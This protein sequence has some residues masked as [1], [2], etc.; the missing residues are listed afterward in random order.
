MEAGGFGH[1]YDDVRRTG[2]WVLIR[3]SIIYLGS[4][5]GNK[6]S[7]KLPHARKQRFLFPLS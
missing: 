5:L 6:T 4:F 7:K 3:Y 1:N 2:T